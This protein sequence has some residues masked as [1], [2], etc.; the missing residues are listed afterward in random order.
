MAPAVNEA[1][2]A[3]TIEGASIS[4]KLRGEIDMQTAPQL[5][6]CL[7]TVRGSAVVDC[8][9]LDFIDSTGIGVLVRAHR[10]FE[11]RHDRLTLRNLPV[12][13]RRVFD[14]AGVLTVLDVD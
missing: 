7:D 9:G 2:F 6:A 5:A 3:I 12:H 14:V 13:V 8:S 10:A 1:D 4:V 11:A